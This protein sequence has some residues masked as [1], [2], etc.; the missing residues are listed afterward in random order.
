MEVRKSGRKSNLGPHIRACHSERS[1]ESRSALTGR[2][3][4][5]ARFLAALGMTGQL[6]GLL[7]FRSILTPDS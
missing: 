5:E 1:E 3:R 7:V 6:C 4:I 2:K